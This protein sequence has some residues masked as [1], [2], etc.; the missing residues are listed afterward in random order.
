MGSSTVILNLTV[1]LVLKSVCEWFEFFEYVGGGG[2]VLYNNFAFGETGS[3][4]RKVLKSWLL[5]GQR[6]AKSKFWRVLKGTLTIY[7]CLMKK[8]TELYILFSSYRNETLFF[9]DI[10]SLYSKKS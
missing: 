1:N 8:N 6:A 7:Y 4:L 10:H 2:W 3:Y 5:E 9:L